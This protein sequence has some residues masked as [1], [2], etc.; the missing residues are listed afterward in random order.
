[1]KFYFLLMIFIIGC[2][3]QSWEEFNL[4]EPK[5]TT[6]YK[7]NQYDS[8]IQKINY[9]FQNNKTIYKINSP[10]TFVNFAGGGEFEIKNKEDLDQYIIEVNSII[11]ILQSEFNK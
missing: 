1:M 8:Y 3:N 2:S 5:V 7:N 9:K 10:K 11:S 6:I 4:R